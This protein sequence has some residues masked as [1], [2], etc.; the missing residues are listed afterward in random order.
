MVIPTDSCGPTEHK[1]AGTRQCLN[2]L[3]L[4]QINKDEKLKNFK[5]QEILLQRLLICYIVNT[6]PSQKEKEFKKPKI[7]LYWQRNKTHRP[8]I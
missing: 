4:Y 5:I 7:S 1:Y 6:Q 8:S 2:R 3:H